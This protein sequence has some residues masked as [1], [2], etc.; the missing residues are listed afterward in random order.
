MLKL[1]VSGNALEQ[2]LL[3]ILL[4]KVD[5]VW[6]CLGMCIHVYIYSI[7]SYIYITLQRFRQILK[8]PI[9]NLHNTDEDLKSETIVYSYQVM[10]KK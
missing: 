10:E 4:D 8:E 9:W 7:Y 3:F 6:A 2:S 1:S 5:H